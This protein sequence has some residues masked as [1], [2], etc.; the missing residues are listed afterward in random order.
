MSPLHQDRAAGS[1]DAVPVPSNPPPW[2][3]RHAE[4]NG[5]RL[6]YV[7]AGQRGRPAVVLLHGF[8]EFWYSWRNQIPALAA[9]GFHVIAPDMRGYNTS[10]KPPRVR[11]YRVETLV[12]DVVSLARQVGGRVH[13]V[14]HD[15]GGVVAW[16]TAMWRPDVVDR[17]AVLNVPHPVPYLREVRRGFVQ[18]LRSWYVFFFQL[19]WL[20]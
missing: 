13:L 11:D 9:A 14:G 2:T 8:P 20:P 10:G 5:V 4:V 18:L 3:H 6:H 17:L 1:A 19:P 15:W 16:L 7:E 12:D